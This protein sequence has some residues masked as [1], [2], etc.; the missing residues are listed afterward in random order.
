MSELTLHQ[1]ACTVPCRW[2]FETKYDGNRERHEAVCPFIHTGGALDW[3][4]RIDPSSDVPAITTAAKHV[5]L[6]RVGFGRVLFKNTPPESDPSESLPP[7]SLL[8]ITGWEKRRMQ[9]LGA[10][11]AALDLDDSQ[12]HLASSI[13]ADILHHQLDNHPE[14]F[15]ERIDRIRRF[16]RALQQSAPLDTTKFRG[17]CRLEDFVD[18]SVTADYLGAVVPC[19]ACDAL[20]FPFE[21]QRNSTTGRFC[22]KGGSLKLDPIQYINDAHEA[23]FSTQEFRDNAYIINSYFQLAVARHSAHKSFAGM[24]GLRT[25]TLKGVGVKKLL[26]VASDAQVRRKQWIFA[27]EDTAASVIEGLGGAKQKTSILHLYPVVQ[28]LLLTHNEYVRLYRSAGNLLDNTNHSNTSILIH[29]DEVRGQEKKGDEYDNA[30]ARQELRAVYTVDKGEQRHG[31]PQWSAY[32][33][34]GGEEKVVNYMS[35]FWEPMM[36]PLIHIHADQQ[37]WLACLQGS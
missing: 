34:C 24:S 19:S 32:N 27:G 30:F 5:Y 23:D 26:S 36:F 29:L 11:V 20:L 7:G 6:Q 9:E 16:L 8:G 12:L 17:A 25:V 33:L 13:A 35:R 28:Q 31:L 10:E 14:L 2:C 18:G 3:R 21:I 1:R 22:C 4:A 15:A 37:R